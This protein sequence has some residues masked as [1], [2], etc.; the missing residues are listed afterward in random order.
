M[1]TLQMTGGITP[2]SDLKKVEDDLKVSL[3]KLAAGDDGPHYTLGK[4]YSA[5]VQI[6]QGTKTKIVADLIDRNG[7]TKKCGVTIWSRPWLPN[8][9]QVTFDCD[10]EPQVVRT[11]DP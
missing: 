6:V 10:G 3:S 8:G 11:H 2:V 1:A 9:I 4:I 5:T 7:K